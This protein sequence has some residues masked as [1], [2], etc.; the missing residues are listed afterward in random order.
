MMTASAPS[1]IRHA[2]TAPSN[3]LWSDTVIAVV[4]RIVRNG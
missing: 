4:R 2:E 1:A 3:L